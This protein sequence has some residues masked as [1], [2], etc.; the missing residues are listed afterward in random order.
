VK[1][2]LGIP[3]IR[4]CLHVL[5]D[6]EVAAGRGGN[7]EL[8]HYLAE[9]TKRRRA[10]HRAPAQRAPRPPAGLVDAFIR[11]HPGADYMTIAN[12]FGT[13]VGRISEV[14]NPP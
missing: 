3:Q 8:L 11:T 14:L 13:N 9:A 1:K 12:A 2:E 7:G 10:V 6:L 5:A 4:H